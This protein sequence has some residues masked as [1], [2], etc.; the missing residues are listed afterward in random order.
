MKIY[1]NPNKKLQLELIK[2]IDNPSIDNSEFIKEVFD[3]IASSGD[4]ALISYI[5]KYDRNSG[6]QL[7]IDVDELDTT[8]LDKAL[9]NAID[10]A[11]DNIYAF[12]ISQ[13]QEAKKIETIKGVECWLDYKAI[14]RVGLYIPGGT[15]PLLS[16]VLM[17]GIPAKI[18]N[19][20]EIVLC[21]P[22]NGEGLVDEAI[23]Y[24]CKKLGIKSIY[25][26][27]GAHAIAAMALGT[28]TV[29]KVDKLFGP[30]NQYVTAAKRYAV[31]LGTAID[32]PAGPSELL[33]IANES[34]NPEYVA[35]DLLSQAEHGSDSQVV[36]CS[37][38]L[39]LIERVNEA[40][41]LQLDCLP[42]KQ[43]ASES[44]KNSFAVYFDEMARCIEFSNLYAPEHLS[45]AFDARDEQLEGIV[46]AGS[47]FIGPYS[48]ESAGDYMSGTNHT[49]PTSQFARSYGGVTLASFQKSVSFQRISKNGLTVMGEGIQLMARAEG[50]EGHARAVSV[51]LNS[52]D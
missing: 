38:S 23:A 28:E 13:R 29:P 24:C 52:K 8:S 37:N 7:K 48:C 42:R 31:G 5:N 44:L 6:K 17:L 14:P 36:L 9:V 50:L 41:L 46:N 35:S 27:G 11:Y 19:C 10:M 21:T 45:I 25:L 47:V 18:A 43:L 15:A 26:A 33:V 22:A 34:S 30:G 32:M 51:R 4:E 40:L 12:H 2:R 39:A 3:R 1:K 16:T 49:L 20:P